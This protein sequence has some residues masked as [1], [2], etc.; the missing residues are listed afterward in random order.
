MEQALPEK[1]SPANR[2]W[3]RVIAAAIAVILL[4]NILLMSAIRISIKR[5]DETDTAAAATNYLADNTEYVSMSPMQRIGTLLRQTEKDR[6]ESFDGHYEAASVAI[7]RGDNETAL[8]EI[9]DCLAIVTPAY[10]G[11]EDLLMKKGCLLALLGEDDRA[12][13]VF[14]E[15]LDRNPKHAEAMLLQSQLYLQNSDIGKAKE[16]LSNFLQLE[17]GDANQLSVM[18]QLC[19]GT[20]DHEGTLSYGRRSL[21][22]APSEDGQLYRAMAYAAM[23]QSGFAEAREYLTKALE[24][25]GEDAEMHYYRGVCSLSFEEYESAL[26][27]FTAAIDGGMSEGLVYYNRAVC[28]LALEDWEPFRADLERVVELDDDAELKAIAESLLQELDGTGQQE[29]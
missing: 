6:A 16:L 26:Q 8:G 17:E 10:G 3:R 23:L 22:K 5:S 29:Q 14:S 13:N 18:A 28:Y 21:E 1:K 9:N 4:L 11:Y 12:K 27:D 25:L 20:G 15:V 7:A 2:I 24:L 19:Y